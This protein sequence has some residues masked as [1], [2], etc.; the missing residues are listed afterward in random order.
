MFFA[1]EDQDCN[2]IM[3]K[4][5]LLK[6][7]TVPFQQGLG[8]K[9]RQPSGTGMDFSIFEETELIRGIDREVYPLI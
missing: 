3:T 6:P 9:F 4:E 5:S 8:Q 7:F 2:L 1:K